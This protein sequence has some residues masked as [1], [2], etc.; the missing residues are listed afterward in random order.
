MTED[1]SDSDEMQVE[2]TAEVV[3]HCTSCQHRISELEKMVA[4]LKE[5]V[6]QFSRTFGESRAENNELRAENN[7]LRTDNNKL[8]IIKDQN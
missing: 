6:K 4:A 2:E 5:Q 3:A 7:E 8:Y 1:A